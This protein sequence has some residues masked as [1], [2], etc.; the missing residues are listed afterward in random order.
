[1]A[2]IRSATYKGDREFVEEIERDKYERQGERVSR[3][4]DDCRQYKQYHHCIFS[5]FL[6]HVL[7]HKTELGQNPGKKHGRRL[8]STKTAVFVDR[9][10]GL[11]TI[12]AIYV[13]KWQK[14]RHPSTYKPDYV[15]GET[16]SSMKT[17][18]SVDDSSPK[19]KQKGTARRFR[20]VPIIFGLTSAS[21]TATEAE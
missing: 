15:D 11:S 8:S 1:M 12:M 5:V 4:G 21:F 20:A 9:W 16:G 18:L 3:R 6:Q 17:A 13:D 14:N 7:V 2:L 10:A 19:E